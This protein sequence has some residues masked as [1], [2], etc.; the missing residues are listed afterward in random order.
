MEPIKSKH[1]HAKPCLHSKLR[2]CPDCDAVEC[3]ECGKEWKASAATDVFKSYP[4]VY[5]PAQPRP[6]FHDWELNRPINMHL[7]ATLTRTTTGS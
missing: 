3:S 2:H 1:D 7:C 4:P 6:Y 5:A